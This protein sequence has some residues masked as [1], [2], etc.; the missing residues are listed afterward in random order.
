[1]KA[2]AINSAFATIYWLKFL[3]HKVIEQSIIEP[4]NARKV[5]DHTSDHTYCNSDA[6]YGTPTIK[7]QTIQH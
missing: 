4:C 1:M 6:A 5:V 7:I 3:F 2:Q